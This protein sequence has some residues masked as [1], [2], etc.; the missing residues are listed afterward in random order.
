M[1]LFYPDDVL[2]TF[3][4]IIKGYVPLFLYDTIFSFTLSNS[5]TLAIISIFMNNVYIDFIELIW[6]P[7][8]AQQLL[9]EAHAGIDRKE[10]KKKCSTT[11]SHV[12]TNRSPN[13]RIEL[14]GINNSIVLGGEWLQY[15]SRTL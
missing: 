2:F 9:D 4:D 10:K 1:W 7:R 12:N 15:Y 11:R 3:I 14:E 13:N 8:C 5:I 6:K